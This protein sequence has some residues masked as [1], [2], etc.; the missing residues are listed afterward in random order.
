MIIERTLIA[1]PPSEQSECLT[2]KTE[3]PPEILQRLDR[4]PTAKEQG[5]LYLRVERGETESKLPHILRIALQGEDQD[6]VLKMKV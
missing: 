3:A 2:P 4:V 1:A 6:P 5:A